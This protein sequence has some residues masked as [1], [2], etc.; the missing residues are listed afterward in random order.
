MRPMHHSKRILHKNIAERS[1]LFCKPFTIF[2]LSPIKTQV[3]QN[4][5]R[6]LRIFNLFAQTLAWSIGNKINGER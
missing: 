6:M 3:L 1:K 2:F 4:N 5:Y